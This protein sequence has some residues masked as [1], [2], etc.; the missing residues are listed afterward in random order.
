[1]LL[2]RRNYFFIFSLN[3]KEIFYFIG[4]CAAILCYLQQIEKIKD[5][6]I[7]LRKRE[8]SLIFVDG[9]RGSFGQMTLLV[10]KWMRFAKKRISLHR[11][12]LIIKFQC[13]YN[14]ICPLFRLSPSNL[15]LPALFISLYSFSCMPPLCLDVLTLQI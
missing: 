14:R 3:Y 9:M 10:N 4:K 1:M 11:I 13:R 6:H 5:F 15:I 8:I 7:L 12:R 2:N